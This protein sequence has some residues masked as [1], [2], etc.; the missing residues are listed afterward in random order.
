MTDTDDDTTEYEPGPEPLDWE[1]EIARSLHVNNDPDSH[2]EADDDFTF[3]P[4]QL[5]RCKRQAAIAKLGLESHDTTTLGIFHTGT[6][7]HEWL[8]YEFG[9]RIPGVELEIGVEQVYRDTVVEG[10]RGVEA[11]PIT[12]TGRADVYDAHADV[13]YDFKTRGGWYKFDPPSERHL[14]QLTLYMDALDAAAGQVVYINK[15]NLEVKTW[16]GG[17]TFAFDPDRRDALVA[18]AVA[19]RDG[20]REHDGT[21]ETAADVPFEPCD[22]WLCNKS[23]DGDTDGE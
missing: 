17:E 21:I 12:I 4:S 15:K 20:L 16:P 2:T 7:I 23:S 1:Q 13:V 6:L 10:S 14:D 9:G 3:H 5:A 18:K 19:I 22:C 8:E 11:E